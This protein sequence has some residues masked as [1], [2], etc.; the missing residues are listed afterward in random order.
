MR[1]KIVDR[2]QEEEDRSGKEA[3]G[4]G[5]NSVPPSNFPPVPQLH[6]NHSIIDK[7]QDVKQGGE[8]KKIQK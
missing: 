3:L 4:E 7:I 2:V 5:A 1:K 8:S 6:H